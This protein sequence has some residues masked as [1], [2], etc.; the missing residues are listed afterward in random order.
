MRISSTIV[1]MAGL[2]SISLSA[3]STNTRPA[4]GIE[5]AWKFTVSDG[6][7]P[8]INQLMVLSVDGADVFATDPASGE[9]SKLTH[10]GNEILIPVEGETNATGN[11]SP[12]VIATLPMQPS[13]KEWRGTARLNDVTV[14][15]F[16]VPLANIWACSHSDPTHTAESLEKMQELTLSKNCAGWHEVSQ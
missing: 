3:Q 1:A 10:K 15:V 2:V 8:A 13:G 7:S 14:M 5:G 9:K 4:D 12:R 11:A 6:K 16:A